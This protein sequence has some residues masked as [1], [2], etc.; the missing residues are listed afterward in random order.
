MTK[1]VLAIVLLLA[2][3]IPFAH[4]KSDVDTGI[5]DERFWAIKT[6]QRPRYDVVFGGDS[7]T[8]HGVSPT[9]FSEQVG[10]LKTYNFAFSASGMTPEYLEWI[11]NKISPSSTK[12][13]IIL[14]I[15][16]LSLTY[17]SAS[18]NNFLA[19]IRTNPLDLFVDS[20]VG[21]V[22]RY[23]KVWDLIHMKWAVKSL[24]HKPLPVSPFVY[25]TERQKNGWSK[26]HIEPPLP[27]ASLPL[28]EKNFESNQVS[29][30]LIGAFLEEV[31]H[32]T[33]DGFHVVG[34]RPP[35]TE[36]MDAL[37]NK[38]SGFDELS[39]KSRFEQAGGKWL[40]LSRTAYPT[41]DGSHLDGNG[42]IQ[43]SRDLAAKI[44]VIF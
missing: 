8:L 27:D 36:A 14:G 33:R 2:V 35:A 9:A 4:P 39:F 7:R 43:L 20:Y 24:L 37:E 34:F 1:R 5:S 28:Y 11:K 6:L 19:H 38:L 32:L 26:I 15:T 42:A 17:K 21:D 23:F 29:E 25:F 10:G 31:K 44:S 40:S 12:K 13:I 3:I 22:Y 18:E 16:P 41:C 30:K